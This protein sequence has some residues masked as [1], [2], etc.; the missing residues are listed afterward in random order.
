MGSMKG[1]GIPGFGWFKKEEV[2]EGECHVFY[3]LGSIDRPQ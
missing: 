2:N 1:G 3:L